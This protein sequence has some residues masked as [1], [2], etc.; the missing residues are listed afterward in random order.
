MPATLAAGV[1]LKKMAPRADI[2]RGAEA[3]AAIAL[4]DK[5]IDGKF[6]AN[7]TVIEAPGAEWR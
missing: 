5:F 4:M 3:P 6:E 1:L 2:E 7:K